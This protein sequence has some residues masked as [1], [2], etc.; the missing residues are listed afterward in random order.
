[1]GSESDNYGLFNSPL[2]ASPNLLRGNIQL[3]DESQLTQKKAAHEGRLELGKITAV[4][5]IG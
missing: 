3:V 4:T 2:P 5:L 1:M